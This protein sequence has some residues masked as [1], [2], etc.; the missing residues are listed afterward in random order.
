M[1]SPVED[2]ILYVDA[3]EESDVA[4]PRPFAWLVVV[5]AMFAGIVNLV[6]EPTS[7]G[8][9]ESVSALGPIAAIPDLGV[10][11]ASSGDFMTCGGA[12]QARPDFAIVVAGVGSAA[13]QQEVSRV[14]Q[15]VVVTTYRDH[16]Y[17]RD[18]R[19]ESLCTLP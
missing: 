16:R 1:A 9:R 2:R 7:D 13:N 12:V 17:G 6:W 18:V 19:T 15:F 11:D 10:F 4:R 3:E 8:P 14:V 5:L